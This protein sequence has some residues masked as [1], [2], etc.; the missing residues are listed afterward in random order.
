[1]EMEAVHKSGEAHTPP[2]PCQGDF[3]LGGAASVA[4]AHHY[5][6]KPPLP[7]VHPTSTWRSLHC[8]HRSSEDEKHHTVASLDLLRLPSSPRPAVVSVILRSFAAILQTLL[9]TLPSSSRDIIGDAF[10]QSISSFY[11]L[12]LLFSNL[13]RRRRMMEETRS[14]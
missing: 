8:R 13:E 10:T 5:D 6:I 1:M 9:S 11:I 2:D 3:L 12:L 7:P 14:R 4:S